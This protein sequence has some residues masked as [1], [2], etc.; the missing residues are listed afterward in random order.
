M[1]KTSKVVQQQRLRV[2]RASGKLEFTTRY[3]NRCGR[4]GRARGYYRKF[5]LCRICVRKLSLEGKLPG[6]TKSSW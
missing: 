3:Y 4:C 1:A 2:A 5:D 6:V